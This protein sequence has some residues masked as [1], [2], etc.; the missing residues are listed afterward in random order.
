VSDESIAVDQLLNDE[1]PGTIL[2]AFIR[3]IAQAAAQ[4]FEILD[5]PPVQLTGQQK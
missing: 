3:S 1:G 5:H 2:L 4:N